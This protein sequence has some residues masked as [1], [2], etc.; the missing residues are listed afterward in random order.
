M[1][2]CKTYSPEYIKFCISSSLATDQYGEAA[3]R[4]KA[5]PFTSPE[6]EWAL[7]YD[8]G[9][10]FF[11]VRDLLRKSGVPFTL[12]SNPEIRCFDDLL[13][14][15]ARSREIG[16]EPVMIRG[17]TLER[18]LMPLY[19]ESGDFDLPQFNPCFDWTEAQAWG[20]LM[21]HNIIGESYVPTV[22]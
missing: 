11:V 16:T 18:L 4:I 8:D 10:M 21:H 20:Y 1:S 12:I 17:Q 22:P 2:E 7:I 13:I 3:M 19:V 14:V 5:C 9:P 15:T 6:L